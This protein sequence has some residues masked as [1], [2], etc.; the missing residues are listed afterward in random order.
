MAKH[1]KAVLVV[2]LLWFAGALVT[3][4]AGSMESSPGATEVAT[5][6]ARTVLSVTPAITPTRTA[7]PQEL[8]T[9]QA[10]ESRNQTAVALATTE[11][12]LLP[13][14]G[15]FSDRTYSPNASWVVLRCLNSGMGVYSVSDSSKA[16]YFSY[17]DVYGSKYQ[18][19]L[20]NGYVLPLH[21]SNDSRYL[22]FTALWVGDG[23]CPMYLDGSALYRLDLSSGQ[24][25]LLIGPRD[26]APYGS[27]S[28]SNGDAYVA[29]IQ[30]SADEHAVL[31]LLDLASLTKKDILLGNKYV[32]GGSL[33]W[34]PDN[35][36]VFFSARRGE[37]SCNMTY[38]LV[39]LDL[40]DRVQRIVLQGAGA[41][42]IPVAWDS[43]TRVIV[44]ALNSGNLFYMDVSSGEI[45]TYT[46]P[47]LTSTP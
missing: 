35:R 23:G 14:C 34:S 13:G 2:A 5:I 45:S 37:D 39:L 11:Q 44:Q 7:S 19:G 33:I 36:Q 18:N 15:G 24:Y 27:F 20:H 4:C 38:Y 1:S 22:Y 21:W 6:V 25:S 28:F 9:W 40:K 31:T 16:W 41:E 47:A 30:R 12:A 26:A 17:N 43:G 42:Y 46:G 3:S 10:D 32:E 29:N 8:A